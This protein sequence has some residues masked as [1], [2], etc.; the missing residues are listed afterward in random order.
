MKLFSAAFL[1]LAGAIWLTGQQTPTPQSAKPVEQAD[2]FAKVVGFAQKLLAQHVNFAPLPNPVPD[3]F[4]EPGFVVPEDP[5]G[6]TE[7]V[8]LVGS[9][10]LN[11]LTGELR[12]TGMV[13]IGGRRALVINGTPR[14]EGETITV[15]SGP[16]TYYLFFKS[17]G[18]GTATFAMD[19]AESTIRFRVN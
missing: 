3:P 11:K 8:A 6:G 9:A 19:G 5:E 4:R 18:N 15:K 12:V 7:P 13:T 10:L 16:T 14:R 17:L 2:Y 1:F